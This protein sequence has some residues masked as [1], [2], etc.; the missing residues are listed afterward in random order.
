MGAIVLNCLLLMLEHEGQPQEL[1][2]AC[3]WLSV[4]FTILFVAEAAVKV[5]A[6]TWSEYAADSWNRF[7]LVVTVLALVDMTLSLSGVDGVAAASVL[8]VVRIA[9]L[10]RVVSGARGLRALVNTL[11]LSLPAAANVGA[12]FALLLFV[13]AVIAMQ[14]FGDAKLGGA[15]TEEMNFRDFP[16]AVYALF[17]ADTGVW[18]NVHGQL[19]CGSASYPRDAC[20][21]NAAAPFLLVSFV[22]L[23]SFVILNIIV[24]V[25]LDQFVESASAEG[26][27]STS[28]FFGTVRRRM[29]LERFAARLRSHIATHRA[30]KAAGRAGR[31]WCL[32]A[33]TTMPP[34]VL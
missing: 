32:R 4:T 10:T 22:L 7:D 26:L 18:T 27:L 29:L 14:A 15:L 3:R 12:V 23:G 30:R 2:L 6:L 19:W 8:R 16:H 1:G 33:A 9:R 5:F 24:A 11:L 31:K 21:Y 34:V 20:E 13:Y 17:V 28:G 25:V